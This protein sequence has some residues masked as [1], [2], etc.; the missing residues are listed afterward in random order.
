MQKQKN[1]SLLSKLPDK[2]FANSKKTINKITKTAGETRELK[3][4]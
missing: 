2:F 4:T 3:K 1:H